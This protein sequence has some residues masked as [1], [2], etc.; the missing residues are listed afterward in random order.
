[1]K[2]PFKFPDSLIKD[3]RLFGKLKPHSVIL[4]FIKID[5]K[6]KYAKF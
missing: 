4:N 3:Y 5:S 2:S 1:M 6:K